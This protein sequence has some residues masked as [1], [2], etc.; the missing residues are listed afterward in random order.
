MGTWHELDPTLGQDAVDATH[1]ALL[2][3]ELA[4]QLKLMGVIGQLRAEVMADEP[5]AGEGS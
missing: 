2:E 4:N 1:V 3:G 5:D